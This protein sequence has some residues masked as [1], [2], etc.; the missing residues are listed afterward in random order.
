MFY[1]MENCIVNIL[2]IH[3]LDGGGI[4]KN[5]EGEEGRNKAPTIMLNKNKM[6]A[7]AFTPPAKMK[8]IT[9]PGRAVTRAFIGGV[10]YSLISVLP[11]EFL[12]KSVIIR[13]LSKA[14]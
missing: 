1:N 8:M 14:F 7:K 6:P 2:R 9:R 10:V 11:N 4:E 3:A 13:V 12:F 5:G